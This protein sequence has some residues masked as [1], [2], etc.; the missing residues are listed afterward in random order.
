MAQAGPGVSALDKAG[1]VGHHE[2]AKV[3]QFDDSEYRLDC[4]EGIISELEVC[5]TLNL[6]GPFRRDR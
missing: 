4:G 2:P 3:A 5:K 1:D 6:Q